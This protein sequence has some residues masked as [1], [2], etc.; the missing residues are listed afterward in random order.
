MPSQ[1][2]QLY[3]G[4]TE[5]RRINIYCVECNFWFGQQKRSDKVGLLFESNVIGFVL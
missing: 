1:P 5:K 4:E 2:L 3:Q